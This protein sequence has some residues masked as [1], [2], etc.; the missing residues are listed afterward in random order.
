[1]DLFP[2]GGVAL[3]VGA[4]GFS[5]IPNVDT[6]RGA[7][8]LFQLGPQGPVS[9]MEVPAP[10][11]P[12]AHFGAAVAAG[13][14]P[15]TAGLPD[16]LVGAPDRTVG[17]LAG[18]GRVFVYLSGRSPA[19]VD[20]GTRPDAGAASDG[21]ASTDGGTAPDAGGPPDA[22]VPVP[23]SLDFRTCSCA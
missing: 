17:T 13:G 7:A 11:Q 10:A 1:G 2:D 3:L 8:F 9:L 23:H 16:F 18:I 12:L 20:G 14:D 4:P 5:A 15:D 21:G 22:G 19:M 6:E